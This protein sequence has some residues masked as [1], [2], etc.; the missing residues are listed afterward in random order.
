MY[1]ANIGLYIHLP[2][3][4]Q[5]CPYCDFNSHAIRAELPERGYVRAIQLDL[6]FEAP[7]LKDR[8]VSSIFFGGGT[9][10]LFSG[11]AISDILDKVAQE[12]DLAEDIEITLEANPGTAEASH[13][14]AYR[15]AGVNRLSLGLQSLDDAMLSRLGRIHTVEES[16]KAFA[17]AREA[18]FD[19]INIDLMFGLP[20]QSLSHGLGDL[21]EAISMNP[22]H[23]SW[24][25]LTLEPNTRFAADPPQLPEDDDIYELQE[26][27]I[28]MLQEAGYRRYEVSAYAKPGFQCRHNLNYWRFGDYLGIG[29]GAHSKLTRHEPIRHARAR[30]P[31]DYIKDSGSA[32]VYQVYSPVRDEDL[33]FEFLLNN[34]R[35]VEGFTLEHLR[36]ATDMPL[37]K[38]SA[39]LAP[40][41]EKG[42][43]D[44]RSESCRATDKGFHYLDE[45][46]L[47]CLPG[48][49]V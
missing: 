28:V 45:I 34:L 49:G 12:F 41:I 27:G 32:N 5:K 23:L 15:E 26:A 35:L 1:F 3:C 20:G 47:A 33:L 7:G 48:Q 37:S 17:M 11:Q 38:L 40:A 25:Q 8:K 22:Q 30:H 19:N 9:P 10:S 31:A 42:M 43:V 16:L 6:E 46:L 29:A 21:A 2:W 36:Q 14:N 24:Y 18:G 39:V 4:V 44:M 13:F